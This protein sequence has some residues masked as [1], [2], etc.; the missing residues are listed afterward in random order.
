[1]RTRFKPTKKVPKQK[2]T[3]P[4]VPK[5]KQKRKSPLEDLR[6]AYVG[7]VLHLTASE[8]TG[9]DTDTTLYMF[10]VTD[11]NRRKNGGDK[12]VPVLAMTCESHPLV[13]M[14][15]V[16]LEMFKD[17]LD[18]ASFDTRRILHLDVSEEKTQELIDIKMNKN[19]KR[20]LRLEVTQA[21]PIVDAAASTQTPPPTVEDYVYSEDE[22]DDVPVH[23]F[24][25]LD[26][27]AESRRGIDV[28]EVEATTCDVIQEPPEA[29]SLGI[30]DT[31]WTRCTF[32]D[33]PTDDPEAFAQ[34]SRVTAA[35]MEGSSSPLSLLML[36][37]PHSFWQH[38]AKCSDK[39]RLAFVAADA[40]SGQARKDQ[41]Y[42]NQTIRPQRVFAFV[43]VL[44]LNMLQPYA[45][46]MGNHW[47]TENSF[48]KRAGVISSIMS[49]DE[50]RTISRCL[51]FY[52]PIALDLKDK[53]TKIR[54]VCAVVNESFKNAIRLGAFVSF[55][56]ATFSSRSTYLPARQYN[57]MK[58]AKF[59]L[60]LF[61][62]CC[63]V[64][65]YC[66]SF[67][68][69]Q[70]KQ[71]PTTA[72]ETVDTEPSETEQQVAAAH[73]EDPVSRLDDTL[74]GPA[75]LLRNCA[76]MH[77]THRTVF[78]DRFYTTVGLFLKLKSLGINAVGTIMSNRR[79]FSNLVKFTT[80]ET[81]SLDRGSLKMAKA[82]IEGTDDQ[83]LSIGWLD[84]KP[85]YMI[86]VGIASVGDNVVRRLRGNK[87]KVLTACRPLTLYHKYMGGVDTHDYMRMGSYSLQ[88]SYHMNYWPKTMFLGILDLVLVNIYI[89]WKLVHFGKPEMKTREDF[90]H[91]LA[92][93][94]FFYKGFDDIVRTRNHAKAMQT[95]SPAAKKA[96]DK[97]GS[98]RDLRP[99]EYPGH[100]FATLLAK[101]KSKTRLKA[102]QIALEE[103]K[104]GNGG[105]DSRFRHCYVCS[106][107][108]SQR[109]LTKYY[110]SCCRA[111]ICSTK[112][113]R[114][115]KHGKPYVCWN[116]LHENAD[117]QRSLVKSTL[118]L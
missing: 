62:L 32:K 66:Y 37:L 69:Y 12:L 86:A 28:D 30:D 38:I 78:C 89:L 72:N 13:S 93:E 60:K 85:V 4:T 74:T 39:K 10:H 35:V 68:L 22:D 25:F 64:I 84:T 33:V 116:E 75:A 2:S 63:A 81:K 41:K 50:F 8:V 19:K 94:M 45:G 96:K 106:R 11:V 23:A 29:S 7:K 20:K 110:C 73:N 40:S 27:M 98:G 3:K 5:P 91:T 70:G 103:Y 111:P 34:T 82:N 65:G 97:A 77:G 55:D 43:S 18:G 51:C 44:I 112:M 109:Y 88:K 16:P 31:R 6:T 9:N 54:F 56:E 80:A 79:G 104:Y 83:I 67:E 99:S 53:F 24:S 42:M 36:M 48:I 113:L 87:I 46:G 101:T 57:P 108:S 26:S 61:M 49:R 102:K 21:I 105:R 71:R 14:Q 15:D 92:E 117:I 76:W 1:M 100:E 17:R 52:D 114:Q 58:P 90:Y 59:G 115:D 95:P 47:R 118:M 107:L